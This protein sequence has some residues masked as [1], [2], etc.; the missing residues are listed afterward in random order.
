MLS[1]A[2]DKSLHINRNLQVLRQFQQ[3]YRQYAD[4]TFFMNKFILLSNGYNE[5]I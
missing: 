2:G 5:K 3:R 1:N 4:K